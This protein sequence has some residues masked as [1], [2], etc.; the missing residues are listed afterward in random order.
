MESVKNERNIDILFLQLRHVYAILCFNA[1]LSEKD[2]QYMMG[3][4][5][6]ETTKNIYTHIRENRRKVSADKLNEYLAEGHAEGHA[7]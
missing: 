2:T 1:D 6:I 3:H 7:F 4:A 5:K